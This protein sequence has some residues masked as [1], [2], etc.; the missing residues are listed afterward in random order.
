MFSINAQCEALIA[1]GKTYPGAVLFGSTLSLTLCKFAQ[2]QAD[3]QALH[4][5]QGHQHWDERKSIIES[6]ICQNVEEI[7]A[8]SWP[9]DHYGTDE[10]IAKD[11][12]WS[13]EQSPGH[14]SVVAVDHSLYGVGMAMGSNNIVYATIQA[15]CPLH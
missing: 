14:W 8:E 2:D 3:Y 9:I 4:Q 15:V 10:S 13:W 12:L 7:C 6:V 1:A 5:Q 11:I